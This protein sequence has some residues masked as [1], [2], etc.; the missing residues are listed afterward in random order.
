MSEKWRSVEEIVGYLRAEE[1]KADDLDFE[2][3]ME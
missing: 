2:K 3:D 1:G